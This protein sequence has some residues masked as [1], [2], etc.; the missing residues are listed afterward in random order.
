MTRTRDESI[1]GTGRDRVSDIQC[2][3]Q[4]GKDQGGWMAE[5]EIQRTLSI[6]LSH[7]PGIYRPL[8]PKE[9]FGLR[10]QRISGWAFSAL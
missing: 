6:E 1:R 10:D 8:R 9:I 7:K 2:K 4:S 3:V 5:D